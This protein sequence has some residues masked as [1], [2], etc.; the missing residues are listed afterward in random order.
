MIPTIGRVVHY[1]SDV[2]DNDHQPLA[3]IITGEYDDDTHVDLTVLPP[4]STPIVVRK[5]PYW[6]RVPETTQPAVTWTWPPRVGPPRVANE[7][8]LTRD[9]VTAAT[10]AGPDDYVL[11]QA[12]NE[13]AAQH[14]SK[15]LH[16]LG[17]EDVNHPRFL[18]FG[19][20]FDITVVPGEL[21]VTRNLVYRTPDG[22]PVPLQTA[23]YMEAPAPDG[24]QAE[25][26]PGYSDHLPPA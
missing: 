11:I 18:V 24:D 25:D 4:D 20:D 9:V 16:S 2:Y 22:E 19:P 15:A 1:R 13:D 17:E 6:D 21:R 26:P 12:E 7:L 23:G 5:V 3:A 8:L 14:V 10:V